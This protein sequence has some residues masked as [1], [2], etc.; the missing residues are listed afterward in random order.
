MI[1]VGIGLWAIGIPMPF[2]LGVVEGL[3]DFIPNIGAILSVVP[4]GLLAPM[5]EPFM[6]VWVILPLAAQLVLGF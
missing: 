1:F 2:T 5:Q 6:L 4:A 3:L